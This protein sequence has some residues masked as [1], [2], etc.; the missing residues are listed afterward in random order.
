MSAE[1]LRRAAKALLEALDADKTPYFDYRR[2]MLDLRWP[3]AVAAWL[4][5]QAETI[6]EFAGQVGGERE[7]D[8]TETDQAA[9][10][11]AR[12]ILQATASN[13]ATA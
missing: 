6:T 4:H 8:L 5:T 9:I 2:L 12:A 11:V 13:G 10:T 3:V 1:L 7:G